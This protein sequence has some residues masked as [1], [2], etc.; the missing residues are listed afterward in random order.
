MRLWANVIAAP[1]WYLEGLSYYGHAGYTRGRKWWTDAEMLQQRDL[2]GKHYIVT[3]ANSGIGF[4]IAEELAKRH[5]TVHMICRSAERAE[6]ARAQLM[7]TAR[8]AGVAEPDLRVHLADMGSMSSVRAF[9][10]KFTQDHDVVHALINN[11]GSLFLEETRT[12][13]GVDMAMAIAIGGSFLLTGLMLPLLKKAGDGRVVNV[14]SGGQYL[15]SLDPSDLKLSQYTGASF[16]GAA[17]YSYSKKLQVQLTRRWATHP[18]AQGVVFHCMHPGWTVTPG[19]EKSL[20]SFMDR[21]NAMMRTPAQGADTAVWL[22]IATE[23]A[24]KNGLFWLDREE[25][26]TDMRLAGD[27]VLVRRSRRAVDAVRAHQWLRHAG[28]VGR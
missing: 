22:A 23:P 1:Q 11:A 7:E 19:V 6:A 20:K 18:A 17:S 2:R 8:A 10:A 27:G 24:Q 12:D 21:H 28:R 3:G 9:A 16:D 4:A 26:R 13:D 5:A 14:S 15:V 25:I